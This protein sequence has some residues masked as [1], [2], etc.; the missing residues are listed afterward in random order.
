MQINIKEEQ[1]LLLSFFKNNNY[2]PWHIQ[3]LTKQLFPSPT[4]Y[5]TNNSSWALNRTRR[6][7]KSLESQNLIKYIPKALWII[8]K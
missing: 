4:E 3:Y 8:N 6:R 7:L 2:Q 5:V 1:D